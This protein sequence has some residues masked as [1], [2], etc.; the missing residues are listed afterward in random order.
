MYEIVL[1]NYPGF[2]YSLADNSYY[3]AMLFGSF[4]ILG[5][6]ETNE[7]MH[8]CL[9]TNLKIASNLFIFS[10]LLNLYR[11]NKIN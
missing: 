5:E 7:K 1:R 9:K 2:V 3:L 8:S 4:G 6:V 11:I 10:A